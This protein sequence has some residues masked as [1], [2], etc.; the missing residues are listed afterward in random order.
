MNGLLAI[1]LKNFRGVTMNNI[2][3]L[4]KQFEDLI[5]QGR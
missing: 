3:D 5:N 1:V 4:Q 2:N